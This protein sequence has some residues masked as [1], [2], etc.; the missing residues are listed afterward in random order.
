MKNHKKIVTLFLLMFV[1]VS[2]SGCSIRNAD[3][4]QTEIETKEEAKVEE[5]Q[6][7]DTDGDGL[8][9]DR[10]KELGTDINSSDTDGDGLSDFDEVVKY[11]TDPLQA[12]TD[13]DG[14]LDK[15]E[16]ESGYDP[17]GDGQFHS[18][19][20]GLGDVDE[21]KYGTDPEKFDTDGDG[22]SDKEEIDLGRDPL[23]KG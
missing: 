9:D 21:R 15:S 6:I 2:F 3:E 19:R 16:I 11:Y 7:I 23:V 20:D 22:L 18:D 10:E 5:T 4:K 8:T 17:L 14:Y 12:D 1:A 13:G